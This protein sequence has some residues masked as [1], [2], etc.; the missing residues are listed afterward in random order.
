MIDEL[1]T[2]SGADH[3]LMRDLIAQFGVASF[4]TLMLVV[5]VLL[6]S[7]LSGVPLFSTVCG[8]TI[9]LIASQAAWGRTALWLPDR[10]LDAKFSLSRLGRGLH[11]MRRLARWLDERTAKRLA[12]LV[13]QPFSR[14][15]YGACTLAGLGLPFMELV[16]FTSSLIGASIAVISVGL[17]AKDGL[18]AVLGLIALPTI[19]LIPIF[20]VSSLFGTG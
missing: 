13:T 4:S 20:A 17:L 5:S 18:L 14:V 1:E 7:P 8:I 15:V 6:V 12:V 19:F 2:L 11:W 16:P 3:L 9:A 10:L